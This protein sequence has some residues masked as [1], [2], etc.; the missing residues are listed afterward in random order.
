[1]L[2]ALLVVDIDGHLYSLTL[3][4]GR[5]GRRNE[6]EGLEKGFEGAGSTHEASGSLHHKSWRGSSDSIASH[7][8]ALLHSHSVKPL[9]QS[10]SIWHNVSP[11]GLF[12]MV[13]G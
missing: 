13:P 12:V 5:G 10:P 8:L 6:D 7:C 1:M 9:L 2:R 11:Q 4:T 3:I